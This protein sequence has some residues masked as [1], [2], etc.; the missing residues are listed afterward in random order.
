MDE[1]AGH[2]MC[3]RPRSLHKAQ[4]SPPW[5]GVVPRISADNP[6]GRSKR[7][8]ASSC[9]F[10]SCFQPTG[11]DRWRFPESHRRARGPPRKSRS[12][13]A[14][15]PATQKSARSC[16]ISS[17][18]TVRSSASIRASRWRIIRSF[19]AWPKAT[20]SSACPTSINASTVRSSPCLR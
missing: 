11:T 12:W 4:V 17:A 16:R 15:I 8:A 2:H 13:C 3:H 7:W 9:S 1:S 19:C 5:S 10:R 20:L 14:T 18:S 6:V